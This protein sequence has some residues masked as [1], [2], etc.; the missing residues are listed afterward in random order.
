M[1]EIM[2]PTV[3]KIA[4]ALAAA[5]REMSG[6]KKDSA[7]PFFKSKYADLAAVVGAIRE[8]F[9]KHGIAHSQMPGCDGDGHYVD[10]LLI[11]SSGEWLK[12]RIRMN[13]TKEDPQG[14]GSVTTYMRRYALQAMAGLEAEDDDGNHASQPVTPPKQSLKP[15]P[16]GSFKLAETVATPK[17]FTTGWRDVICHI[18]TKG[19]KVE[20]KKLANLAQTSV[21]WIKGKLDAIAEPSQQDNLLKAALALRDVE[22][23]PTGAQTELGSSR[24]NLDALRAKAEAAKVPLDIIAKVSRTLGGSSKSFDEIPEDEAGHLIS[25][26]A[27]TLNLCRDEMDNLPS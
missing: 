14:I 22:M 2:S 20:G 11:H 19:G 17:P 12:S 8:P 1:N 15:L 27:E 21:A 7:N 23:A 16:A 13:P 18:G 9:A 4:E 6:A 26:F 5:Q 10:T 3:A 25:G 24:V